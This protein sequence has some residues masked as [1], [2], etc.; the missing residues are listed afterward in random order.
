MKLIG[1]ILLL[2]NMVTVSLFADDIVNTSFET[3]DY[4]VGSISGQHN[5]TISNG[6]A[7]IRQSVDSV[8]TGTQSLNFETSSSLKTQFTPYSS[9]GDG[10]SGV[11]YF[12]TRVRV[13]GLTNKYFALSGYDL[14]GGSEKR[15]FVFEF[16]TPSN[17]D[18]VFQAYDSSSKQFIAD[19]YLD[20][21]YRLSAKIDYSNATYQVI[22]N[23]VASDV[24]AFRESYTPS[25]TGG[26]KQF[27]QLR[28]NLGYDSA[29]GTLDAFLD[30]FYMGSTPISGVEF[31]EVIYTWSID[32]EDPDFGSII[33]DPDLAEYEDSSWVTAR[34]E[35][36]DGYKLIQWT[37]NLSGT[38]SV[39]TFQITSNMSIGADVAV[40]PLNPPPFYTITVIQPVHGSITLTP[41]QGSYYA[42]TNV[43]ANISIDGG[44]LFEGWT[45]DLSGN[46]REKSFT[47]TDNMSIGASVVFDTIPAT[48]YT[49]SSASAFEDKCEESDLRPGDIIELTNGSYDTG[50]INVTAKGIEGKPIIIRAQNRGGTTLTG[51]SYFDLE[52]AEYITIEGFEFTSETYTVIKLEAC[53]NIHITRNYFRLTNTIEDRGKWILI[54]GIWDDATKQ[55]H[56]NTVDYN[57]FE[58]K[59]GPGNYI[60][61]DGGDNVSQYDVIAYNYFKNIGPRIENEMEA[62]RVG[63]SGMSLTDGFTLIE[64]NLFEDCDGDP[65][66]VS[67]KSCKDTVRYNTFIECQGTVCLRQGNESVVDGNYFFGNSKAGTGGVRL[68]SRDHIIVNN[69]FQ[70]LTGDTWDAAITMTNGDQIS[71]SESGHWQIQNAKVLNNTFVNTKAPFEIGYAKADDSW[72]K[73]PANCRIAGNVIYGSENSAVVYKSTPTGFVWEKNIYFDTDSLK[74]GQNFSSIQLQIADPNIENSAGFYKPVY[75]GLASGYMTTLE[76]PTDIQGQIRTSPT[77]AGAALFRGTGKFKN[78]PLT[79]TDVGPNATELVVVAIEDVDAPLAIPNEFNAK[80]YPNPFNPS[81]TLSFKLISDSN[82]KIDIFTLNGK[83]VD[84]LSSGYFQAGEHSLSWMPDHLAGGIYLISIKVQNT[85]QVLKTLYLK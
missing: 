15:G 34:V 53:N 12:D 26:E 25:R 29:T 65:E 42:H 33:L 48:V 79:A 81:M 84:T 70:D 50:G 2:L 52:L 30:D 56:H 14:F 44:Y 28:V 45:G 69:H 77:D 66:I 20:T 74:P 40:D 3:P 1:R 13:D 5:W 9:S 51:D 19:Y 82:V 21:W 67:I 58:N 22:F 83:F 10:P 18:G 31:D 23:G 39:K 47:I 71:G 64:H 16:N 75:G 78:R 57:L 36:P 60:T 80:V 49:F 6:S 4:N 8:V 72:N 73:V 27:H 24:L 35:V 7:T 55:S 54:G 32:V 37:G 62:V 41:M 76:W 68:Y 63:V 46:D 11:I 59:L 61:I 43:T 85:V 17:G 38:D